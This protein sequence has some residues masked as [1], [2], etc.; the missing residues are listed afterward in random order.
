MAKEGDSGERT[1]QATPRRREEAREKGQVA[2]STELLAGLTLGVALGGALLYGGP[3][4]RVLGGL[5]Q[6]TIEQLG[7]VGT[8]DLDITVAN[9]VLRGAGTEGLR[10]L[11]IFALPLLAAA[12][13]IG[14]AQAGFHIAPKAIA[15]ESSKLNP[16]KGI[17]RM[18]SMRSVVRTGLSM[19]KLVVIGA[20]IFLTAS[21]QFDNISR[22]DS[23][24]FGPALVAIGSIVFRALVG[25]LI[26]ILAIGL[27]DFAFQR[28]QHERDLH[29]TKQEVKEEYKNI[30]GDPHVKARIRQVQREMAS[31][32]MMSAVPDASV[33]VTNPT[34]YA[35]ALKYDRT[36][37]DGR[38][39]YVV[40]KGV[41]HVAQKIKE[42][43]A[44]NEVV[45]YEDVPLARALHAQCEIGDEIPEDLFEA[46]ASVLAYVYRLRERHL[47]A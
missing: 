32:R 29:M 15:W 13:L 22:M 43:A 23:C 11:A 16:V 18:F 19:L 30:D 2:I 42:I 31:R 39:P 33:V 4:M 21:G 40:A 17:E 38:A 7:V 9:T 41:D 27:I 12:A 37:D 25:G 45:C 10:V 1:E 46:V 44:E 47:T 6:E 28:W 35:V 24:E 34:H 3:M 14:Y 5:V 26:A 8:E 20:T 36:S